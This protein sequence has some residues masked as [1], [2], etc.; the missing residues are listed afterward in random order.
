[1]KRFGQLPEWAERRLRDATP[2]ELERADEAAFDGSP[3]ERVFAL[4]CV[5]SDLRPWT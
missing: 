3:R 4:V 1:V 2:E 5:G